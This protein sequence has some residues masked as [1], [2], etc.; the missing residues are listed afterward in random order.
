MVKIRD[1][2]TTKNGRGINPCFKKKLVKDTIAPTP[3]SS[4]CWVSEMVIAFG[5]SPKGHASLQK[6]PDQRRRKQSSVAGTGSPAAW[7]RPVGCPCLASS[8]LV[9][10]WPAAPPS[11][12]DLP[13]KLGGRVFLWKLASAPWDG[14]L[15]WG[16]EGRVFLNLPSER[17]C[18]A[19][20]GPV[21]AG[22][23]SLGSWQGP[24]FQGVLEHR[25]SPN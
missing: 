11:I 12:P 18:P 17:P 6:A 19:L 23:S 9:V 14:V 24:P 15:A 22:G 8:A 16:L 7:Q 5:S 13:R 3:L 20:R 1:Q 10:C 2:R 21:A 25:P 4:S